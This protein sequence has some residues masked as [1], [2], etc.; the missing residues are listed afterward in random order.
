MDDTAYTGIKESD[1]DVTTIDVDRNEEV[2]ID[3]TNISPSLAL[4]EIV[5]YAKTVAK[6]QVKLSSTKYGS[7]RYKELEERLGYATKVVEAC[8]EVLRNAIMSQSD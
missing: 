7:K 1:M 4:K 8:S 5:P 3:I 6:L 2:E